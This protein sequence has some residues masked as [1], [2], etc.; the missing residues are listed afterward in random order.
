[1]SSE[2]SCS[3]PDRTSLGPCRQVG[4]EE[5]NHFL[6][7]I[8]P[9]ET[10]IIFRCLSQA[11]KFDPFTS[12][13]PGGNSIFPERGPNIKRLQTLSILS[14]GLSFQWAIWLCYLPSNFEN[15]FIIFCETTIFQY[16]SYYMT[17]FVIRTLVLLDQLFFQ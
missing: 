8:S 15:Y 5:V 2:G 3:I 17:K 11:F 13:F 14:L 4:L 10:L 1:M 16:E 12:F 6:G 7:F 9:Q